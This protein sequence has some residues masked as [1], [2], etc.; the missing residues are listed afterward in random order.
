MTDTSTTAVI[1]AAEE[2]VGDLALVMAEAAPLVDDKDQILALRG[3]LEDILQALKYAISEVDQ[4]VIAL[5]PWNETHAP[6]GS[7]IPIFLPGGGIIKISGG[8]VPKRFDNERLI[9][10]IAAVVARRSGVKGIVTEDGEVKTGDNIV[11]ESVEDLVR[12][13]VAASANDTAS[14][15]GWRK[16]ILRSYGID[17]EA[18]VLEAEKTPLTVRVEGRDRT[19]I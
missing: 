12:A 11:V 8:N 9:S 18:Y 13:F 10:Q 4:R 5:H 6:D 2:S 1:G 16:T 7:T 14:F 17:V 3:V 19:K 15:A